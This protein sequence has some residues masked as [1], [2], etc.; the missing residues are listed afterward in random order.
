MAQVTSGSIASGSHGFTNTQGVY[1]TNWL[2]LHWRRSAVSGQVSTIQWRIRFVGSGS[3]LERTRISQC[4]LRIT[5]VT[6]TLKIGSTTYSTM[7]EL[8]VL[9]YNSGRSFSWST[10]YA[11]DTGW[12]P[13]QGDS[14]YSVTWDGTTYLGGT[15]TITHDN[16][17]GKFTLQLQAN[18]NEHGSNS[19]D[20]T[21]N[22]PAGT[23]VTFELPV[24]TTACTAPTSVTAS[25]IVKPGGT[26]TVSW[27]GATAGTGNAIT[28]YYV[29]YRITSNGTAPTTTTYTEKSDKIA[30]N[31]S[32]T[33]FTLSA[34][35]TRGWKIVCG[36]VTVGTVSGFD[37]GMK[38]GGSVTIN[39]LPGA[40]TLSPS[41]DKTI[42]SSST[43]QSVTA[44]AGSDADS[45]SQTLSVYYATSTSG[46]KTKYTAA[47]NINPTS[48]NSSTYY[49]WTYDGLEYSDSS[50]SITITKN[51]APVVSEVNA[52]VVAEKKGSDTG[53]NTDCSGYAYLITPTVTC[54]K[55]GTLSIILYTSPVL[56]SPVWTNRGTLATVTIN[57]TSAQTLGQQNVHTKLPTASPYVPTRTDPIY[58]RLGFQLWDDIENSE[59]KYFS[60]SQKGYAIPGAPKAEQ[61]TVYNQWGTSDI[62][63]TNAGEIAT[64]FTVK[65]PKD[66]TV[67][68]GLNSIT[69]ISLIK[70]GT[71]T[72]YQVSQNSFTYSGDDS[73]LQL[74]INSDV[75]SETNLT[76]TIT[77]RTSDQNRTKTFSFTVK[78]TAKPSMGTL[79]YSPGTIYP[80]SVSGTATTNIL[81]PWPFTAKDLTPTTQATWDQVLQYYNCSTT[82]TTAI[83]FIEAASN[84][85]T[86]SYNITS[87]LNGQETEN[88]KWIRDGDN[89]KGVLLKSVAY[90]FNNKLGVTNSNYTGT[91]TYY[92]ALKITNLFGEEFFAWTASRQFNFNEKVKNVSLSD[93]CWRKQAPSSTYPALD[94]ASEAYEVDLTDIDDEIKTGNYVIQGVYLCFKVS[95]TA[96]STSDITLSSNLTN[97][98]NSVGTIGNQTISAART[99]GNPTTARNGITKEFICAYLVPEV[100]DNNNI[101]ITITL[102]VTA[103]TTTGSQ[104]INALR[105]TT[106]QVN[107]LSCAKVL[108]EGSTTEGKWVGQAQMPDFG[109]N[110]NDPSLY[111]TKSYRLRDNDG[112]VAATQNISIFTDAPKSFNWDDTSDPWTAKNVYI[113]MQMSATLNGTAKD[114]ETLVG[115]TA[116]TKYTYSNTLAVYTDAPTVSY[117]PNAIGINIAELDNYSTAAVLINAASNKNLIVL[118]STNGTITIN[119]DELRI[120]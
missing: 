86:N 83:Q 58:W 108:N 5:P 1:N 94:D 71:T 65:F 23:A 117:R 49:F 87:S 99:I 112:W 46:A 79:T 37:S 6:G 9:P 120:Y 17:V 104:T 48:G 61:I 73:Y 102:S 13:A 47:I 67:A 42:S 10:I 35:A 2:E 74:Q 44:T 103:G 32:S 34:T 85:G 7:T 98:R 21:Y 111:T 93:F 57:T 91:L 24:T 113:R 43:G 56:G 52:T 41:S 109:I 115:A 27:S 89:L 22:T 76:G 70:T 33:T 54:T 60:G 55:T 36:V 26:F 96:Y 15:F 16:G 8:V 80:F 69:S 4:R 39:S 72:S 12:A 64:K 105:L 90:P 59:V 68:S 78:E 107:L 92:A 119:L 3:P 14:S 66:T 25:G 62:T 45:S 31:K 114:R 106:G 95:C 30:A 110:I 50:S 28:G 38:T 53:I 118:K 18:I 116:V 29:Y 20:G 82:I 88:L 97:L 63:G 84:T 19:W 51:I 101:P 11:N 75:P 40:P 81:M 77:Y 100:T